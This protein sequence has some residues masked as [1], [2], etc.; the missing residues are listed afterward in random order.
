MRDLVVK[1]HLVSRIRGLRSSREN[2]PD[3]VEL[4]RPTLRTL[5]TACGSQMTSKTSSG[6]YP[7]TER[8]S[9]TVVGFAT[10]SSDGKAPDLGAGFNASSKIEALICSLASWGTPPAVRG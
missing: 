7:E 8:L 5:N 6:E 3:S 1:A 10:S 2:I 4:H 9:L